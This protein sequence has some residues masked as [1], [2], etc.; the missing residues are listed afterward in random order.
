MTQPIQPAVSKRNAWVD[1]AKG[2]GIFLVVVGH[3]LRG[4]ISDH[5]LSDSVWASTL[6]RWIYAFHMPLFFL[7]TGFFIQ[8]SVSNRSFNHFFVNKLKTIAYPYFV[9]SILQGTIQL[10]VAQTGATNR[11]LQVTQLLQVVYNP[12]MQF[13]F[14]YVLFLIVIA[15]AALQKMGATPYFFL[16]LSGLL[17]AVVP[18]MQGFPWG[19]LILVCKYALYVGIGAFLRTRFDLN[20]LEQLSSTRLASI[21][22]VS[23]VSLT[24]A[25]VLRLSTVYWLVPAIALLGII[26]VC[27]IAAL[28]AKHNIGSCLRSWGRASLEIYVAHTLFSACWRIVLSRGLN[29]E[30]ASLH[31]LGGIAIGLYGPLTVCYLA[32]RWQIPYL[33][34]L[35]AFG[36]RQ[37]ST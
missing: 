11:S 10:L 31:L 4:L 18:L 34:T 32:Q 5:I 26:W 27:T 22:A 2:I 29:I 12:L 9:W 33:F 37:T 16:G 17:Y 24:A 35:S 14:L 30:A 15:Y 6:D 28:L 1:Y 36:Q 7:I 3:T 20:R 23:F 19:V 21:G 8:R 13:W 25:V